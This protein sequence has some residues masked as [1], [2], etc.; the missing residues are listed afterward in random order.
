MLH[1]YLTGQLAEPAVLAGGLVVD[2]GFGSGL[3]L[4]GRLES[5]LSL[6]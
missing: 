3:T 1:A 6:A 5:S 2:A 4:T